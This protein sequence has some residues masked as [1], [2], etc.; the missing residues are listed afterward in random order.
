MAAPTSTLVQHAGNFLVDFVQRP[1]DGFAASID[2]YSIS[3]DRLAAATAEVIAAVGQQQKHAL[4]V[5]QGLKALQVG[6][7]LAA[8]GLPSKS[9]ERKHLRN[10]LAALVGLPLYREGAVLSS[11]SNSDYAEWYRT[12]QNTA[13]A[14]RKFFRLMQRPGERFDL[15]LFREPGPTLRRVG[16]IGADFFNGLANALEALPNRSLFALPELR[17]IVGDAIAAADVRAGESRGSWGVA[18][19][20]RELTATATA[21]ASRRD[22]RAEPAVGSGDVDDRRAN[23]LAQTKQKEREQ[24]AQL[25]AAAA[26]QKAAEEAERKADEKAKAQ[27][28][29]EALTRFNAAVKKFNEAQQKLSDSEQQ[30][31][32]A[33]RDVKELVDEAD[34]LV[35]S[36]GFHEDGDDLPAGVDD[37]YQLVQQSHAQ[38]TNIAESGPFAGNVQKLAERNRELGELKRR[39]LDAR[40][41]ADDVDAARLRVDQLAQ[42]A[43]EV[44]A[45]GK[46]A[47]DAEDRV[48]EAQDLLG[49]LQEAVDGAKRAIKLERERTKQAKGKGREL[50]DDGGG[51]DDP[52][53][54]AD[55]ALADEAGLH[56]KV[57]LFR[58]SL[59]A[60]FASSVFVSGRADPC[61]WNQSFSLSLNDIMPAPRHTSPTGASPRASPEASSAGLVG[62]TDFEGVWL[63]RMY[64]CKDMRKP[65][66]ALHAIELDFRPES[67]ADPVPAFLELG[68][69]VVEVDRGGEP[70]ELEGEEIFGVRDDVDE[71]LDKVG[72]VVRFDFGPDRARKVE[73]LPL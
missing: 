72:T 39:V 3:Q 7:Y 24:Q 2:L 8:D 5:H 23:R 55:K 44:V 25:K 32:D 26:A 48:A 71:A 27:N 47:G 20:E 34:E 73:V 38:V 61:V 51:S 19:F 13:S 62:S 43:G 68:G 66:R 30:V 4:R 59:G 10:L 17:V 6:F 1:D 69:K 58:T 12:L 63:S 28:R 18:D 37:L 54:A 65:P 56:F 41:V 45:L 29:K 50:E 11:G 31:R 35:E 64:D 53:A 9:P 70:T 42:A 40:S 21:A 16:N 57:R 33:V 36:I 46:A 15:A 60:V 52:A 67:L 49:K 22:A 14:A